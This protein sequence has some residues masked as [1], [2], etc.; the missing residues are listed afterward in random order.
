[1]K[2]AI[3]PLLVAMAMLASGTDA[4]TSAPTPDVLTGAPST[5]PTKNPTGAPS[6]SPTKN[7]TSPPTVSP[8]DAPSTSP[9][10]NPTGAP[11][12]SPTKNP[13]SPPTVS[14]TDAPSTSPTKN[15][16]GAPSVP[17]T[18]APST[19]P[20]VSP[21]NA[22]STSPTSAAFGL[23]ESAVAPS[24]Y[25]DMTGVPVIVEGSQTIGGVTCTPGGDNSALIAACETVLDKTI[26][27]EY[28]STANCRVDVNATTSTCS[29][30]RMLESE[31]EEASA[32]EAALSNL[33]QRNLQLNTFVMEFVTIIDM[34]C[35]TNDCS[36]AT[37]IVAAIASSVEEIFS[38]AITDGTFGNELF[39]AAPTIASSVFTAENPTFETTVVPE[40]LT[41]LIATL[42]TFYP[43][44]NGGTSTCLNDGNAPL[45]M[46]RGGFTKNSLEECC[47]FYYSWEK[48]KCLQLGGAQT[49][50]FATDKFYV[51]YYKES[52]EQ[53]CE[54]DT[55]GKNCGGLVPTW[56][57]LF[58][59]AED[60]C[61]TKLSWVEE[62]TCQAESTLTPATA[63]AGSGKYY[64]KGN[65]CMKDCKTGTG[66]SE[67]GGLAQNWD[68]PLFTSA[69]NCCTERVWWEDVPDCLP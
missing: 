38:D 2:L 14:P 66:D 28:S 11:S 5:S 68:K 31:E 41:E 49:S 34:F 67:C 22:P 10:K 57:T 37:E 3:K 19:P 1:M 43:D 35:Q 7:P 62:S 6:T 47:D 46:K 53:D 69:S 26:C 54:E 39:A 50:E 48:T 33:R 56:K 44:W 42:G 17:P 58:D 61:E 36:D 64:R 55:A 51:N 25:N 12:T 32:F 63:P 15:P 4:Q 21:T 18:N 59:S 40:V 20:T 23:T 9:T 30:R 13:T 16:T 60:C 8:T 65:K 27:D 24:P 45:Y 52:C 29:S